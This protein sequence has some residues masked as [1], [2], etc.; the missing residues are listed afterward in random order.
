[1]NARGVNGKMKN[2]IRFIS[3][4][5]LIIPVAFVMFGADKIANLIANKK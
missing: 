1:M 4:L 5:C 2:R 3:A